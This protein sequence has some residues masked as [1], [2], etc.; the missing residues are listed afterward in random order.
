MNKI[1]FIEDE[2][3]H[4]AIYKEKLE[5]EGFSFISATESKTAWSFIEQE[6]PDLILLD[7]LLINENGL[8]ILAKLKGDETTKN[9]PVIIFTNYDEKEYKN[10]ALALGAA[11]FV[12]KTGVTPDE[13]V[14]KIRKILK[15]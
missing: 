2:P 12:P 4:I 10:Q 7:I 6:K 14:E 3:D 13:M 1:L 5:Q 11:D 9:I 8:E 15:K